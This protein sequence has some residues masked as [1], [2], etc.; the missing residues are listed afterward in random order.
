MQRDC[1]GASHEMSVIAKSGAILP[2][3][4]FGSSPWPRTHWLWGLLSP[5]GACLEW[6]CERELSTSPTH[7]KSRL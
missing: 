7:K 4:A 3:R 6:L 2:H 1:A 5:M